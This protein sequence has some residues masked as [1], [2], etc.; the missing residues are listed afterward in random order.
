ME[1]TVTTDENDLIALNDHVA[2]TMPV[3]RR[4]ILTAWLGIVV[5]LVALGVIL[6]ELSG[7]ASAGFVFYAAAIFWLFVF[8]F[9]I[10][11]TRRRNIRRLCR[12]S[13]N[14]GIFGQH[15]IV[16]SPTEIAR[17]GSYGHAAI[18]WPAV[19]RIEVSPS[20]AFIFVSSMNAFMIPKLDFPNEGEFDSFVETARKYHREADSDSDPFKF[21]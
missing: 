10:K 20:H 13:R 6:T 18:Y 2:R 16:L 14:L 3:L 8:P 9:F 4:Q 5:A 7:S 17:N 15:K 1:V 12:S 21:D 19:D 11:W